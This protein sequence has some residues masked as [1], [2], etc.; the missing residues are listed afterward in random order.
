MTSA[1]NEDIFISKVDA[2][3]N[4][5][6]QANRSTGVD[7]CNSIAVDGSEMFTQQEAL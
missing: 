3:G 4:F 2:S 7:K 6:G 1:G 5:V